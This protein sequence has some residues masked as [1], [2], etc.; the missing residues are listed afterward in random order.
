[1]QT[2]ERYS[3]SKQKIIRINLEKEKNIDK[4]KEVIA[5]LSETNDYL[6]KEN[7]ELKKKSKLVTPQVPPPLE[8]K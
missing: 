1:M 4:L 5:A 7:E 3:V 8:Q 2:Y 6:L